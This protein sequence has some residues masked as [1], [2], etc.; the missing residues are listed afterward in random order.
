MF[1]YNP[2]ESLAIHGIA[3]YLSSSHGA[4][5]VTRSETSTGGQESPDGG[6]RGALVVGPKLEAEYV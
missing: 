4:G 3:P 2:H 5:G 1:G 6:H